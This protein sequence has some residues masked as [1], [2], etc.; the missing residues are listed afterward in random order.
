MWLKNTWHNFVEFF[1]PV[2][3][4]VGLVFIVVASRIGLGNLAFGLGLGLSIGLFVLGIILAPRKNTMLPWSRS[5]IAFGFTYVLYSVCTS[6]WTNT[7]EGVVALAI[8]FILTP[9]KK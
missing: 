3:M 4:G 8:G 9:P 6:A 5:F 2:A 7:W 1:S